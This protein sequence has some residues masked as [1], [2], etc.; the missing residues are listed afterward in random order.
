M[1]QTRIQT[2]PFIPYE[3]CQDIIGA[4]KKRGKQMAQCM[5]LS[6]YQEISSLF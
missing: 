3:S 6:I 2:A 4:Q 5:T 1:R